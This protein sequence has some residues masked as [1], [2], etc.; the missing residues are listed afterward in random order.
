MGETMNVFYL[1]RDPVTAAQMHCDK[2]VVKMIVEYAQLMSTAHR[3]LDGEHWYGRTTNGRRISR[4]FHPDPDMN[5]QLYKASHMNHP[6]ALWVRRSDRNYTWLYDMWTALCAEYTH[7]YGR[8]HES[9]RKL[10]YYL[11]LPPQKMP[12]G[13]F[14]QPTPAM[15]NRPECIVEGDSLESY[16]N[17]YWEDKRE[18]ANWTNR[19]P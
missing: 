16:R 18:F 11:L 4:F 1:D 5:A 13:E 15:G 2:H 6:S 17:Y 8:I 19:R 14:T 9:F 3:V 10:E 7:R 12:G